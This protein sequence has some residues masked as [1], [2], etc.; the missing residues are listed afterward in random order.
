M[1]DAFPK[2]ERRAKELR[3]LDIEKVENEHDPQ[4]N[5]VAHRYND[6]LAEV[7]GIESLDYER[8]HTSGLYSDHEPLNIAWMGQHREPPIFRYRRAWKQGIAEALAHIAS[9]EQLFEEKLADIG[10]AP[11]ARATRAFGE[12]DIHPAIAAASAA[13]FENKHYANAVEDGC[14]A[15]QHVVQI[16]SGRMDLDGTDLM[17][18][19]FS[20]K[21]PILAVGDLGTESGRNEQQG[22][23]FM[24]SGAMSWL[25]NPRAHELRSDEPERAIEY[26]AFLSMLAKIADGARK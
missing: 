7:F 13:L 11:A 14:K 18:T 5:S 16:K 10:E 2:L 22:M 12:L 6:T 20:P 17:Q 3:E 9:I 25:R 26:I 19:V 15:L 8:Y 21:Q 4:V 23:M 1:R 24:A